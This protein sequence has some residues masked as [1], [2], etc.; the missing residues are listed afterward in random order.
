MPLF[1]NNDTKK[2]ILADTR[3]Q[4]ESEQETDHEPQSSHNVYS[5][6]IASCSRVTST[7]IF[8]RHSTASSS[9]TQTTA[10]YEDEPTSAIVNESPYPPQLPPFPVPTYSSQVPTMFTSLTTPPHTNV[11]ENPP[12]ATAPPQKHYSAVQYGP[13]TPSSRELYGYNA[14]VSLPAT[15]LNQR[16]GVSLQPSGDYQIKESLVSM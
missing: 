5:D 3:K 14:G 13:G 6:S 7:E 9:S 12:S 10:V 1:C 8:D 11:G 2:K 15:P 16:R 4:S